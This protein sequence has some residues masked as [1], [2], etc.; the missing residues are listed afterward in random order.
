MFVTD[1]LDSEL[2]QA[3]RVIRD[4]GEDWNLGTADR[5]VPCSPRP[6]PHYCNEFPGASARPS[7]RPGWL[8]ACPVRQFP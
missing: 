1:R 7:S 6:V 4:P 5:L 8:V 3:Y 2:E